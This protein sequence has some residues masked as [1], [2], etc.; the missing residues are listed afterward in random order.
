MTTRGRRILLVCL[1]MTIVAT[2]AAFVMALVSFLSLHNP[3]LGIHFVIDELFF[4]V[5]ANVVA[6]KWLYE[7]KRKRRSD[8]N[9]RMVEECP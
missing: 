7:R 6:E 5:L 3:Y 2:I 9:G 4:F 1:V 8:S